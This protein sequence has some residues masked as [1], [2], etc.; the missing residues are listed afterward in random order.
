MIFED[1]VFWFIFGVTHTCWLRI[2]EVNSVIAKA[3]DHNPDLAGTLIEYCFQT[4]FTILMMALCLLTYRCPCFLLV[5]SPCGCCL[6]ATL[7]GT[8]HIVLGFIEVWHVFV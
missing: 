2:M 5:Q 7:K 4:L 3:R 1:P 8:H 6:F